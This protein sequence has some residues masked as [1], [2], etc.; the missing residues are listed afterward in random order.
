MVVCDFLG[1]CKML[2]AE[3]LISKLNLEPLAEGGY[4][5][6]IY[7]SN[8]KDSQGR[9]FGAAIYYLL[10]APDFSCFHRIDCDEMWHFYAGSPLMVYQI[11]PNGKLTQTLLGNP[12]DN[13]ENTALIMVP[14]GN[15]FAAEIVNNKDFSLIGC[16]TTPEFLYETYEIGD[17]N[18]LSAQFPEHVELIQRLTR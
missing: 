4:F 15:W 2:T 13:S 18:K 17:A 10:K 16:T 12:L 14:K 9:R 5:Q 1:I 3:K 8:K 6:R 7:Q 11:D